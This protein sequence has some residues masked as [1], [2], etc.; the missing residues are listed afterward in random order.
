MKT[1]YSTKWGRD[2]I[3]IAADFS[4]AADQI[5]GLPGYQVADFRHWPA[6]AM[7][8]ALENCAHAEG[9]DLDDEETTELIDDAVSTMF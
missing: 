2:L 5:D 8:R 1:T 4:Q 9:M 3:Q 6:L 7:R